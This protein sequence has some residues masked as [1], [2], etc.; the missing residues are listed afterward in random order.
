MVTTGEHKPYRVGVVDKSPLVQAGLKQFLSEDAR[1]DLTLVCSNGVE[2]ID[3]LE[4]TTIDVCIV[5]WVMAS[6][7]GKYILDHLHSPKAKAKTKTGPRVV[8]FTGA[9]GGAVP[10]Q[11]MAHGAAA[12]VSKSE[13]PETLLDTLADVAAGR[14]VF[15]YMDVRKINDNPLTLLTGRELEVLSSLAAGRNNKEIAN[16]QGV[17]GNTVKFHIRNIYGKLQVNSRAQAVAVYLRS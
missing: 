4:T 5:G 7:D 8:V 12:F 1:F 13:Q 2:F 6:G 15:P 14:M 16:E 17:S 9:E 10:A 3:A 11:A